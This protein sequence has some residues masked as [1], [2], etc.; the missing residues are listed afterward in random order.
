MDM[1][2]MDKALVTPTF[3]EQGRTTRNGRVFLNGKPLSQSE[4][5]RAIESDDLIALF[6]QQ[7]R[8]VVHIDLDCVK[9]GIDAVAA[10]MQKHASAIFVADAETRENLAC[11]SFATEKNDIRLFCGSAGLAGE[12]A[13]RYEQKLTSEIVLPKHKGPV[14]AV[15]G[16][17][18]PIMAL[19]VQT[20]KKMGIAVVPGHDRIFYDLDNWM[21]CVKQESCRLLKKGVDSVITTAGLAIGP[22]SAAISSAVGTTVK[23]IL[24]EERV[25]GLF[26][27]GGNVAQ[28]VCEALESSKVLLVGQVEAGVVIGRLL[29]GCYSGLFVVTKAGGFGHQNTLLQSI[30]Y[31]KNIDC[32]PSL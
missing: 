22:Q 10:V 2:G 7:V 5:G 20:I 6:K 15:S 14:L 25:G 17:Q 29:D 31:L 11:L 26:L 9:Q 27:T 16:S 18:H 30:Q 8:P 28:A 23:E 19:Q 3:P 24:N 4:F 13:Q 32:I 12:L 21:H 1:M